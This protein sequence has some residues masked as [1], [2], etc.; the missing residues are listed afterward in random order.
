VLGWVDG[1]G[2][3]AEA[4]TY[5]YRTRGLAL[6]THR[7]RLRQV[8]FDGTFAYSPTVEVRVMPGGGDAPVTW[9]VYPNP[10]RKT[11]TVEVVAART[12]P[13]RI[14]LFDVLGRRVALLHDGPLHAGSVRRLPI[15]ASTLPRGLYVV[16]AEGPALV[17][18]QPVVVR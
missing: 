5:R 18:A 1:H 9:S 15:P 3:T 2:T 10:M 11:G 7:Y 12:Q 13:V 4:Q 17:A 8:D 16:R 14:A 6:G